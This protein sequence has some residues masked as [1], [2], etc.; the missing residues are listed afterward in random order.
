MFK[1]K[2]SEKKKARRQLRLPKVAV[3][4][5]QLRQLKDTR[6]GLQRPLTYAIDARL[7]AQLRGS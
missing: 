4:D 3:P 5:F 7:E 6:A 1:N 2:S